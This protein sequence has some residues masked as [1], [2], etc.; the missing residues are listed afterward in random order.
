MKKLHKALL[1]WYDYV[2]L[3]GI[4]RGA[5]II[6]ISYLY[7]NENGELKEYNNYIVTRGFSMEYVQKYGMLVL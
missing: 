2:E 5:H 7:V 1:E 4:K 3:N 6:Y